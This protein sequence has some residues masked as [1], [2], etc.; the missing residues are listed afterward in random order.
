MVRGMNG[1]M[2]EGVP[3]GSSSFSGFRA[4]EWQLSARILAARAARWH[5]HSQPAVVMVHRVDGTRLKG[6]LISDTAACGGDGGH[7]AIKGYPPQSGRQTHSCIKILSKQL[8]NKGSPQED[9]IFIKTLFSLQFS[10]ELVTKHFS[11][12]L[13]ESADD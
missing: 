1:W 3:L 10:L 11:E 8:G 13:P 6:L 2:S 9:E 7:V 12:I 5:H 4:L